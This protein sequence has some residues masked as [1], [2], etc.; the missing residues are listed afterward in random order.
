[1]NSPIISLHAARRFYGKRLALSVDDLQIF[2]NDCVG[3]AG[4]NG[5]GKS[6]LLRVFAGITR[7]SSGNV[8]TTPAWNTARVAYCPQSGGLYADL[9]ITE[10]IRCMTRRFSSRSKHGIFE[11]LWKN[12]ELGD[13]ADTPVRKLSGGF[14]KLAMIATALAVDAKILIFDEP[15]SDLHAMY[16]KTVADLIGRASSHYLAV[17]FSDHSDEML[18]IATRKIELVR[19]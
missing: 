8:E 13:L 18:N 6:T 3:I 9:T 16:Q 2:E 11:E 1:M 5:A 14:Q 7:L 15:T 4:K 19:Q 17:V 12:S 10:N